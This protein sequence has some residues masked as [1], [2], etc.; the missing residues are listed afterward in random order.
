MATHTDPSAAGASPCADALPADAAAAADRAEAAVCA[1]VGNV[2]DAAVRGELCRRLALRA[3]DGEWAP[4]AKSMAPGGGGAAGETWVCD[5]CVFPEPEPVPVA[6]GAWVEVH[7]L[8][9]AALNGR[10]GRVLR[11]QAE[12]WVVRLEG[13]AGEKALRAGNL[14][15]VPGAPRP[16]AARRLPAAGDRVEARDG[17]SRTA[18]RWRLAAGEAGAV[19][20]V[21]DADGH[22]RVRNADGDVSPSFFAPVG[23]QFS[24]DEPCVPCWHQA[25]DRVEARNGDSHGDDGGR[26]AAGTV[27][28]TQPVLLVRLDTDAPDAPG[29][30]YDEVRLLLDAGE[31]VHCYVDGDDWLTVGQ[32]RRG[33]VGG[34]V[35]AGSAEDGAVDLMLHE[36]GLGLQRAWPEW[37][38]RRR[39]TPQRSEWLGSVQE[40][41]RGKVDHGIDGRVKGEDLHLPGQGS[42]FE[43]YSWDNTV[44]CDMFLYGNDDVVDR[45]VD[46]GRLTRT[47]CLDCGSKRCRPAEMISHSMT[48]PQ[49]HWLFERREDLPGVFAP[50]ELR[51]KTLLDVGSRTGAVLWTAARLRGDELA[52]VIGVE[53]SGYFVNLQREVAAH[54]GMTRVSI[55][56]SDVLSGEGLAAIGSADVL[57]LNN[58]F[59]W[60]H[61]PERQRGLWEQLR[62]VLKGREGVTLVTVPS[63]EQLITPLGLDAAEWLEPLPLEYPDPGADDDLD[64]DAVEHLRLIHKYRSKG[65]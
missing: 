38:I 46:E 30:M 28:D 27:A 15:P 53:L 65:V 3:A 2:A 11:A 40:W 50:G 7:S 20:E 16:A 44:E 55:V 26:W 21:R 47:Y 62:A 24:E 63:V 54:F 57:V 18:Q 14:R 51:G 52:G 19:V 45:M 37:A 48:V 42:G 49:L 22:F 8:T 13:G 43:D 64:E 23:W 4:G 17:C 33:W 9:A 35:A 10:R 32:A 12:R 41:I 1:I 59:Q 39:Y 56:E 5:P 60:F 6:A 29:D 31:Q 58:V 61:E 34:T 25:G 36:A